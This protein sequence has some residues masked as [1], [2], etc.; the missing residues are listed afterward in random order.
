MLVLRTMIVDR[1]LD[2]VFL[3]KFLDARQRLLR[4]SHHDD[5]RSE[6][7]GVFEISAH[8]AFVVL[9]EANV[10][11]SQDLNARTL[12]IVPDLFQFFRCRF[13]RGME[14]LDV[15]VRTFNASSPLIASARESF[16]N[17]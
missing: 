1:G 2:V 6:D 17:E 8:L 7:F 10:P 12:E 4:R 11:D 14:I 15:D 13:H 16:R 9:L 5:W 3:D